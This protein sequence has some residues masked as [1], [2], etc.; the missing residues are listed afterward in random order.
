MVSARSAE[1][2][3]MAAYSA[4]VAEAAANAGRSGPS[5]SSPAGGAQAAAGYSDGSRGGH[6]G[7]SS[8]P[9]PSS[10]A[11]GA[12]AA[13]GYSGGSP[14]GDSSYGGGLATVSGIAP[15]SVSARSAETAS[16]AALAGMGGGLGQ[17]AG[18]PSARQAETS[19]MQALQS[20][21]ER[22][23]S[24][25]A[26]E[27]ASLEALRADRYA[28]MTQQDK[29]LADVYSAG[30]RAGLTDVEARVA[31]SQA[32][33]ET[34]YGK[35]VV[36]NNFF[37]IKAG[38]SWTGPTV[39]AKT[40][41]EVDGRRVNTTASFRSYKTP[42]ESLADW[43]SVVSRNWPGV[44]KASSFE[45]AAAALNAGKKGGYATD[46]KYDSKIA[47]IDARA[48]RAGAFSDI[49]APA[50]PVASK[51]TAFASLPDNAPAPTGRPADTQALALAADMAPSRATSASRF[52]STYLSNRAASGGLMPSA[53][54]GRQGFDLNP[55]L[56]L[57]Q[58]G[59][60]AR[61]LGPE[62]VS[63]ERDVQVASAPQAAP[64]TA[65][66]TSAPAAPEPATAPTQDKGSALGRTIAAGVVDTG[67]G[68]IPGVGL[69]ATG[70]NVLAGLTGNR[71]LGERAVDLFGS[72]TRSGGGS[73]NFAN[74]EGGGPDE[75]V[76]SI[77]KEPKKDEDGESR[78]IERYLAFVDPTP[79]PS[80]AE[81]WGG[82]AA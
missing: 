40:W 62:P 32:A 51:G 31:A 58:P 60:L 42:E 12:Q 81:K 13:A 37:G 55:N 39:N 16:M 57:P 65:P 29:F 14:G 18:M 47:S 63:T 10:P 52:E 36:G 75:S 25:R 46:S 53:A 8:G 26:A 11:G 49:F 48:Q 27:T 9:A 19:S 3:S 59:D 23:T 68:L 17:A 28:S 71:T 41:E 80:P 21:N 15:P 79:R 64:P 56:G 24:Y 67:L 78:F 54:V 22:N 76:A 69:A 6:S 1:D 4:A 73:S 35:S 82:R 66:A 2:A 33:L 70:F 43:K 7:V 34:R 61:G 77:R 74:T 20:Y 45:E 50:V 38:R 72:G 44:T 30:R 5:A